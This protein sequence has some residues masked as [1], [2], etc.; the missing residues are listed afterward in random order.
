VSD[1]LI[2]VIN[3][4]KDKRDMDLENPMKDADKTVRVPEYTRTLVRTD[5]RVVIDDENFR[6]SV[7]QL[8]NLISGK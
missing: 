8:I 2:T 5:G 1:K 3:K 4:Y 7:K 6:K